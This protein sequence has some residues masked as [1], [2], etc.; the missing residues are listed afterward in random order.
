[1]RMLTLHQRTMASDRPLPLGELPLAGGIARARQLADAANAGA[2]WRSAAVSPWQ[3]NFAALEATGM[4][5]RTEAAITV[6]SLFKLAF[7]AVR[8]VQFTVARQQLY[9]ACLAGQGLGDA[10]PAR[11][12]RGGA[13]LVLQQWVSDCNTLLQY[14]PSEL[15][16]REDH[17]RLLMLLHDLGGNL[18]LYGL[19]GV[20]PEVVVR[21]AVQWELAEAIESFGE[22]NHKTVFRRGL[23]S[24]C[25]L[26]RQ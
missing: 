2:D 16:V 14:V 13:K 8:D 12:L 22:Q 3:V 15:P 24:F 25:V 17:K 20:L 9:H 7:R 19:L 21:P 6:E 26:S 18:L 10:L 5:P 11:S 4:A 1:M 23:S